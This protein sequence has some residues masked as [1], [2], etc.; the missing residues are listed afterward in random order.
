MRHIKN[1][2]VKLLSSTKKAKFYASFYHWN[3]REGLND[4]KAVINKASEEAEVSLEDA[5]DL[6][7]EVNGHITSGLTSTKD[8]AILFFFV[9]NWESL[10]KAAEELINNSNKKNW[11][12]FL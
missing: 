3:Q 11:H 1:T 8:K 5:R 12:S 2:R 7:K 6:L 4:I 10:M 9:N